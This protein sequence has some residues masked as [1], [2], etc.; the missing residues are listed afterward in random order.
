MECLQAVLIRVKNINAVN[1]SW[2]T[3]LHQPVGKRCYAPQIKEVAMMLIQQGA[4][5]SIRG[6]DGQTA[7]D[8]LRKAQEAS[9]EDWIEESL[10]EAMDQ[11]SISK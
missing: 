9:L 8:L 1:N 10:C 3:A 6:N 11:G 5:P 2:K 4:D 7:A